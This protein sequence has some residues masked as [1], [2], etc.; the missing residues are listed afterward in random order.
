MSVSLC[1]EVSQIW[2]EMYICSSWD[3][4][5]IEDVNEFFDR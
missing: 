4:V 2:R 5:D 1:F 3:Y